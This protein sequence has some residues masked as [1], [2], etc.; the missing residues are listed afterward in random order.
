MKCTWCVG[1]VQH[2]QTV[3]VAAN[4][5]SAIT[6]CLFCCSHATLSV[7]PV[8]ISYF[9]NTLFSG[10]HVTANADIYTSLYLHLNTMYVQH[11]V[12]HSCYLWGW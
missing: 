12:A 3:M 5:S 1:N 11:V 2:W 7:I 8:G 10:P 6:S 9:L 4:I